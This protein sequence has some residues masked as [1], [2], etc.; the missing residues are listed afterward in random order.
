VAGI[1]DLSKNFDAAVRKINDHL[2]RVYRSQAVQHP[3]ADSQPQEGQIVIDTA[4][5]KRGKVLV[6]CETG[7]DRSAAVVAAY[8]MSVFGMDLVP[9]LQ[10]IG[11]QRFCTNFDDET[12]NWLNSYAGILHA[13]RS[14]AMAHQEDENAMG[15]R[16]HVPPMPSRKRDLVDMM[17][18]EENGTT[19]GD[20]AHDRDRY[21]NRDPF[22]PFLEDP[23]VSMGGN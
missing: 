13:R 16:G 5:F 18:R 23:D 15:S 8:I 21:L 19:D 7:N 6:Y 10:F 14:V 3:Q 9:T 17:G 20:P 1:Q 2:L 11:L 12:K 4:N 22:V